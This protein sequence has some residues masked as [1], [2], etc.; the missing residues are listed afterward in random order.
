MVNTL[1][2]SIG[3]RPCV[4][5]GRGLSLDAESSRQEQGLRGG[6]GR[7]ISISSGLF[8]PKSMPLGLL[9]PLDLSHSQCLSCV[10]VG[11]TSGLT[12]SS[13]AY[14]LGEPR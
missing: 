4:P 13:A 6:W 7:H 8:V 9:A 1:Q 3:E 2:T 14:E 12:P 5:L 10:V 11:D